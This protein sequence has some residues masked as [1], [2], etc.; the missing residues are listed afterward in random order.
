[1]SKQPTDDTRFSRYT[2]VA[3]NVEGNMSY[4]TLVVVLI[5]LL[6]LNVIII[7][8]NREPDMVVAIARYIGVIRITIIRSA[9]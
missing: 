8:V 5:M 3:A 1:V 6:S 7:Y 4:H 9:C 2:R